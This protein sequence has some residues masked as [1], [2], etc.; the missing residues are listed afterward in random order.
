MSLVPVDIEVEITQVLHRVN[1]EVFVRLLFTFSSQFS[2]PRKR[3][4][5]E[6]RTRPNLVSEELTLGRVFR[7][8]LAVNNF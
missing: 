5:A 6:V 1:G 4:I 8:G 3:G 2:S 7:C